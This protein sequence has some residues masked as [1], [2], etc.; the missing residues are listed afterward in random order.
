[1]GLFLAHRWRRQPQGAVQIDWSNPL[2]RQLQG[3]VVA[4]PGVQARELVT[5]Q[6]FSWTGLAVGAS[7]S[8]MAWPTSPYVQMYGHNV[9]VGWAGWDIAAVTTLRGGYSGG[10]RWATR[11]FDD[12]SVGFLESAG[13]FYPICEGAVAITGDTPV[14]VGSSGVLQFQNK[15]NDSWSRVSWNARVTGTAN[16]GIYTSTAQQWRP[17]G[18]NSSIGGGEVLV[19]AAFIWSRNLS[20]SES[21]GLSENPWQIFRPVRRRLTSLPYTFIYARPSRDVANTGWARVG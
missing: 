21:V 7:P 15:R 2:T 9:L 6:V 4:S 3:C 12:I 20:T 16:A 10:S 18:Y 14:A 17:V 1:M 5:G 11:Y 13:S 8:G 19:S